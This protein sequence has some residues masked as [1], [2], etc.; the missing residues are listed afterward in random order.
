M[1]HEYKLELDVLASEDI[2]EVHEYKLELDVL[3]SAGID[4]IQRVGA[5]G[6]VI[7][8]NFDELQEVAKEDSKHRNQFELNRTL[9]EINKLRRADTLD[10]GRVAIPS[11]GFITEYHDEDNDNLIY[12]T[13]NASRESE[14]LRGGKRTEW[15][16]FLKFGPGTLKEG[17]IDIPYSG[18]PSKLALE[19]ALGVTNRDTFYNNQ[20]IRVNGSLVYLVREGLF[21]NSEGRYV[22]KETHDLERIAELNRVNC[23]KLPNFE[24]KDMEQV[25]GFNRAIDDENVEVM[26]LTGGSG[27]GKSVIAYAAALN[28]ILGTEKQRKEKK[29]KERIVLFKTNDII[30]S[31][32]RDLGFLPGS[33]FEKVFPYMKSFVDVHRLCGINNGEMPFREMLANPE[34]DSENGLEKRKKDKIGEFYLPKRS[35]AIEIENLQFAR[36]RT[37]TNSLIFIDEAQNYNPHEMKQLLERIG[38]GCKTFIVGD[39]HQ[40]DNQIDNLDP[41]FN[42]LVWAANTLFGNHPRVAYSNFINPH[43]SQLAEIIRQHDAPVAV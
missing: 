9:K 28:S 4:G 41:E 11:G 35:P 12:I 25:L 5:D 32:H 33:E 29:I 37:F 2:A 17:V 7:Y 23:P 18:D 42:G 34:H 43:R 15:P 26:F 6:N 30:G 40:I 31:K 1:V 21:S 13:K 20:H 24:T 36:G 27:S 10:D 8:I 14:L 16:D 39:P 3:A 38:P 19:D 22:S